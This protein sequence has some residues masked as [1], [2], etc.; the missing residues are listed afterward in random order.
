MH[1]WWCAWWSLP[2]SWSSCWNFICTTSGIDATFLMHCTLYSYINC[3]LPSLNP[4]ISSQIW[5][6]GTKVEST[7]IAHL[8]SNEKRFLRLGLGWFLKVLL[9]FCVDPRWAIRVD[10][11]RRLYLPKFNCKKRF[12][13]LNNSDILTAAALAATFTLSWTAFRYKHVV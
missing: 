1:G 13:L 8:G 11:V 3:S 5:W 2:Y 6:A 10:P 9:F 7:R 12:L 4:G